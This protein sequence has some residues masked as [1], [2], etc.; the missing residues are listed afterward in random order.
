MENTFKTILSPQLGVNDES[1]ILV[2]WFVKND[3]KVFKGDK[4][5][6]LESTKANFEV[7]SEENGFLLKTVKEGERIKVNQPIGVIIFEKQNIDEIKEK[8]TQ[9]VKEN[10]Y[11]K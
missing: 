7:T 9:D 6:L 4:I 11:S 2:E 8:L 10:K 1:A 3:E 5:C